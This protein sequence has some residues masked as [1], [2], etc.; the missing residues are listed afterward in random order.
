MLWIINRTI[1]A[2]E[3]ICVGLRR[4]FA[5]LDG[6]VEAGFQGLHRRLAQGRRHP[7]DGCVFFRMLQDGRRDHATSRLV[8]LGVAV[9]DIVEVE[10][11]GFVNRKVGSLL[12]QTSRPLLNCFA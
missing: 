11:Q 12:P 3:R 1:E 9:S 5:F 4:Q 8:R 10:A 2:R 6:P 7:R